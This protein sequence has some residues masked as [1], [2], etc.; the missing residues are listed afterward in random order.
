MAEANFSIDPN[1]VWRTTSGFNV[2]IGTAGV[3]SNIMALSAIH[4]AIKELT[5]KHVFLSSL[6]IS[7]SLI[8]VVISLF[9]LL[10]PGMDEDCAPALMIFGGMV[11]AM[12]FVVIGNLTLLAFDLYVAICKPLYYEMILTPRRTKGMI[13]AIWGIALVIGYSPLWGRGVFLGT[14]KTGFCS[15]PVIS[16]AKRIWRISM[17]V[18]CGCSGLASLIFYAKVLREVLGIK[19]R[20]EPNSAHLGSQQKH[21]KAIKTILLVTGTMLLFMLPAFSINLLLDKKSIEYMV[22][23][24]ITITWSL[25]NCI[26]DPLI[27]SFRMGEI[28]AGYKKILAAIR[29]PADTTYNTVA[30]RKT[31]DIRS[32]ASALTNVD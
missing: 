15:D 13:V 7:D 17:C 23:R 20:V 1:V 18:F 27:Y 30:L 5:P 6:S 8:A 32:N 31:S 29:K 26:A 3:L 25:L 28:R 4:F 9:S 22:S 14:L 10:K 19:E 12:Y 11:S 2:V 24:P 16:A 21:K